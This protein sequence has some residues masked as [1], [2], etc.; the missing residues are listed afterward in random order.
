MV[1]DLL[2]YQQ[3]YDFT[4]VN[5]QDE[6]FF[7]Y[8]KRMKGFAQGLIEA[9]TSFSWAGTMRA[10]QGERLPDEVWKLCKDAG[11]RRLLIGVESGSQ[12]MMDWMKKDVKLT[13]VFYCADKCKELD[14]AVIFPFIV[15]FPEE[16]DQSVSETI[17]VVKKLRKASS[18]FDTPIFYFKPYPGS[19]ITQDVVKNGYELPKTTLDWGNFDYVGASG[20]WVTSKKERFFEHFKFYL[21]LAYSDQKNKLLYPLK[22]ISQWRCAKNQFGFPIEKYIIEKIRPS[23]KLS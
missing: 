11:L 10:D 18:K 5:F 23:Q 12:E 4:D 22:K 9:K 16:S 1:D 7:T 14:I 17:K 21:K 2:Y 19:Q 13:Q 20:P 15:G 8:A 3:K 6:T